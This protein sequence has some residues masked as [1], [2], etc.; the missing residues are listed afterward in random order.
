MNSIK[1]LPFGL[2][3]AIT[4]LLCSSCNTTLSDL[5]TAK[6]VGKGNVEIMPYGMGVSVDYGL[7]NR[8]DVRASYTYD[9]LYENG[10]QSH[11]ITIAPK[12]S[13]D[14]DKIAFYMPVGLSLN[15]Q[16]K[17]F[18]PTLLMTKT[19]SDLVDMTFAPKTVLMSNSSG[20]I[21]CLIAANLGL[22]FNIPNTP[23]SI[24]PQIGVARNMIDL[25]GDADT[26]LDASV[27]FAI[28]IGS[29][30]KSVSSV[31][32]PTSTAKKVFQFQVGDRVRF[33]DYDK[34]QI[35]RGIVTGVNGNKV[36]VNYTK[37]GTETSVTEEIDS[38]KLTLIM[39]H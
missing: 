8:I 13:L 39:V 12:F 17:I 3:A 10:N 9:Q 4:L 25:F 18:Q 11:I 2:L 7:T 28:H 1:T 14:P 21:N 5:Q 24:R 26:Y 23:F 36:S 27:G 32:S 22:S 31:S 19:F 33:Y 20:S 16:I 34:E 6:T 29:A 35:I 38:D 37:N 30:K 15:D